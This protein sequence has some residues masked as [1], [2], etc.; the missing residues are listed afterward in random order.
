MIQGIVTR[1]LPILAAIAVARFSS[2]TVSADES[3]SAVPIY[4]GYISQIHC[5]G[6]LILSSVGNPKLVN[7]SAI[8]KELGC[9]V[10]IEAQVESGTTDILLKT[11]TGDIHRILEILKSKNQL[12]ASQLEIYFNSDMQKPEAK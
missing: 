3:H 2:V 4:L 7:L 9:G 11:S 10:L 12:T 6:R 1:T 8:P 5:K